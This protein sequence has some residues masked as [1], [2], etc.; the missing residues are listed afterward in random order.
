MNRSRTLAERIAAIIVVVAL[1]VGALV[2]VRTLRDRVGE[3]EADDVSV[4][5]GVSTASASVSSLTR[6]LEATGTIAYEQALT[7]EST[8]SGTV[9]E[10]VAAG[11]IVSS[12]DVLAR[13]D[14]RAIVWL[15]GDVPA[16]RSLGIGAEGADVEQLEQALTDLGFNDG[17]VTVDA[18]YT[19]ATGDMVEQWQESLELESTGD[20]ELG[21]VVFGG[22]R[23][24]VAAVDVE[25]GDRVAPGSVMHLGTS[26]RVARFDVDPADAVHLAV[27]DVID[28]DLPDRTSA[29]AP[30]TGIVNGSDTWTVTAAV[31]GAELTERD[32]ISVEASWEDTVAADILTIPSSAL[33]RLDDGG[34]VVDVVGA[35]G[36]LGRRQ[37]AIGVSEG[38]RTEI[39]SG[40]SAGDVVVVL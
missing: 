16:W 1:G 29:T 27:G 24:R 11:E 2:G 34:Y 25:V 15:T 20:V 35:G 14:D 12:G 33:L 19:E 3:R 5:A 38:T 32:T 26:V 37:V 9:L 21:S 17:D 8:S 13:I 18:E 30:V 6:T 40:L 4:E 39:V 10:I 7:V 28:V 36:D 23:D 31:D 22:D